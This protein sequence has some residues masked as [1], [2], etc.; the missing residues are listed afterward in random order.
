MESSKE[1]FYKMYKE[2]ITSAELPYR[3]SVE[4][5]DTDI[6]EA[7]MDILE[8]LGIGSDTDLFKSIILR[9]KRMLERML[10]IEDLDTY[11][12]Y[13]TYHDNREAVVERIALIDSSGATANVL[14]GDEDGLDV[15]TI[16]FDIRDTIDEIQQLNKVWVK[17]FIEQHISQQIS[18]FPEEGIEE[19]VNCYS[20]RFECFKDYA[21]ITFL[22]DQ[23]VSK[24]VQDYVFSRFREFENQ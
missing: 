22:K 19:Y 3:E 21:M 10:I 17:W 13:N 5:L 20:T 6:S 8:Q 9:Y 2:F 15:A 14:S 24:E 4:K 12:T 18:L 1:T 11:N 16:Y 23:F 7:N